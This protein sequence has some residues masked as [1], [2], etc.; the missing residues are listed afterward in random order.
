MIYLDA[1]ASEPLRPEARDAA[2]AAM[3]AARRISSSP[4]APPKPMRW[5][6]TRWALTVRS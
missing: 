3:E 4:P 1:N 2:I 6:S 5:L